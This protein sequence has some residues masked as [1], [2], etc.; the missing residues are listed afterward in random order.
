MSEDNSYEEIIDIVKQQ[1][2]RLDTHNFEDTKQKPKPEIKLGVEEKYYHRDTDPSGQY[3][4]EF[5]LKDNDYIP[6]PLSHANM[7]HRD[8]NKPNVNKDNSK[9]QNDRDQDF[10]VGDGPN[11]NNGLVNNKKGTGNKPP[12]KKAPEF[13]LRDTIKGEE[14]NIDCPGRNS[15]YYVVEDNL[16][17]HT[18]GIQKPLMQNI[19]RTTG[20]T[21]NDDEPSD[22]NNN[23]KSP[24][25]PN[26]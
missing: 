2:F 1:V 9:F 24:K 8:V 4:G 12:P 21:D 26:K 19:R 11:S 6:P 5:I 18:K 14:S 13:K 10:G 17:R 20:A 15:E 23:G 25:S 7:R 22:V 3:I 16:S